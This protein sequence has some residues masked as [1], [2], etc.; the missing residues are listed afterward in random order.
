MSTSG[1]NFG[2]TGWRPVLSKQ[3]PPPTRRRKSVC[4]NA[5]A[6]LYALWFGACSQ[7]GAFRRPCGR[8]CSWW[9]RILG[10]GLLKMEMPF[11]MLHGDEAD[12]SR[13][14]VIGAR[15]FVHIK[16]SRTLNAAAWEEKVCGYSKE[17]KSYRV[18]NLKSHRPE[19]W[20]TGTS[21]SLKHRRTCFPRLQSSLRC[22]LWYHRRGISTMTL[23]TMTTNRTT[24]YYGM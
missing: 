21:P 24:T 22:K 2:S 1:R 9:L 11:K 13:L 20:R 19:S 3:S 7:T 15:S 10:T 8:S 5:W 12:L 4:P 14:R 17:R 6:G 18:W 16:D 23:R